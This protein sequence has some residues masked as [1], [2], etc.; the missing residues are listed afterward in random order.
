MAV[1]A[2][3]GIV[4]CR[5]CVHWEDIEGVEGLGFCQHES[6]RHVLTAA[7]FH[8]GYGG[9]KEGTVLTNFYDEEIVLENCTVQILRNTATGEES[10]GWWVNG[11]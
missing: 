2:L 11:E 1:N 7:R 9:L 10:V 3:D 4:R 5:D 6:M 8:C